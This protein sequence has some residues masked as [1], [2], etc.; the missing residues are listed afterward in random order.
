MYRIGKRNMSLAATILVWNMITGLG[1]FIAGMMITV[2]RPWQHVLYIIWTSLITA[3]WM[4]YYARYAHRYLWHHRKRLWMFHHSHHIYD[5]TDTNKPPLELNDVLG[6]GQAIPCMM[7]QAYISFHM[8][9]LSWLQD[10]ALAIT[11]GM[12]LF[13]VGYLLVHDGLYHQR[14]KTLGLHKIRW[15]AETAQLHDL[16]HKKSGAPF[17]FFLAR[18][19][20]AGRHGIPTWLMTATCMS[21]GWLIFHCI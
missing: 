15:L 10:T 4:E 5:N 17:G 11:I 19:E 21:I 2:P 14:F 3:I 1:V 7:V 20:L 9:P 13:G 12:S 8:Q 16:H 6:A 18:D